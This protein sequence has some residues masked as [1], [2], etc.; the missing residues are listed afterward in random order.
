MPVI[1]DFDKQPE[2]KDCKLWRYMDFSKFMSLITTSQLYFSRSDKFPDI[3][4]GHLS[5]KLLLEMFTINNEKIQ[6]HN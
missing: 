6:K 3:Y 5:S 1:T 4:E 2:D